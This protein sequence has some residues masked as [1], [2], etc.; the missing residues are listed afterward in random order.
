MSSVRDLAK[1]G[2]IDH[3]TGLPEVE[4]ELKSMVKSITG[5]RTSGNF[6]DGTREHK[7]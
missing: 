1:N 4:I 6:Q 2:V 5:N 3:G 7:K